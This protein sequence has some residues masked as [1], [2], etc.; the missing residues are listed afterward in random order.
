[1]VHASPSVQAEP[2]GSAALQLSAPSLHD[3]AQLPSPSGP[4]QG[5]PVCTLQAPPPQ[6]SVPVQNRPS[7]Q[8][9]PFGSGAV[10]LSAPSLHDS[11]QL[12]SPSGPGQGFPVCT[13]QAPALQASVPVQKRPSVQADPFGSAAVQLSAPS[14]HDSAQLP[15][16]SG[17]G[18]GSPVD[19]LQVPPL[20]APP[21]QVSVPVQNRP[22]L[23]AEPFASGAVQLSAPS[24][25][26]S[27]QLPSP[28][29]PG[30]GSPV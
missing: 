16:P 23:Q 19:P 10:Q 7:V 25:H 9:E 2:F 14:L 28:S 8:A 5:S 17:P 21:L 29:G 4:G 6:E 27:A 12:P 18:H 26:D 30:Q 22:S 15:S 3:S 1:M 24:L 20:Q 13:P 11:A